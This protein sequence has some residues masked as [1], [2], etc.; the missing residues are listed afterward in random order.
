MEFFYKIKILFEAAVWGYH[1]L[2][3]YKTIFCN[4][5]I[6]NHNASH[7]RYIESI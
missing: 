7:W 4:F 6:Y 3:A 1:K 2:S 5:V